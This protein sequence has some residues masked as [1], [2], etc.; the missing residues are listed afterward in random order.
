MEIQHVNVKLFVK[1][2]EE[3]DLEAMIPVFHSWIQNQASGELLLD[4]ADYRHVRTGSGVILIGHHGNY[5]LDNSDGRLG[6]RYNRKTALE[7]TNQDRLAQATEA[8]LAACRRLETEPSLGGRIQFNGREMELIINDRLLAPNTPETCTA[9]DLEFRAFFSNLFGDI[10]YALAYPEDSRSL[11]SV[12]VTTSQA[13]DTSA[14][15]DNL[16]SVATAT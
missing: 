13:F 2:T 1:N 12:H 14:L 9:A 11:F 16:N 5:S 3:V 7:G 10:E 8:A 6:V 15:L 4:V